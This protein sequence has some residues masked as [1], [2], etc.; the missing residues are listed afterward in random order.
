MNC[1]DCIVIVLADAVAGGSG[2][3]ALYRNKINAE[4]HN[5]NYCITVNKFIRFVLIQ[6]EINSIRSI[7]QVGEEM[8]KLK[9]ANNRLNIFVCMYKCM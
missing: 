2:V 9:T 8:G 5:T 6:L 4:H 1:L 3:V 7:F